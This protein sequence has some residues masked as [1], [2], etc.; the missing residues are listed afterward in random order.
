LG[1]ETKQ[2]GWGFTES[3]GRKNSFKRI[4]NLKGPALN[5]GV[6]QRKCIHLIEETTNK[7]P[8]RFTIGGK[9]NLVTTVTREREGG[10]V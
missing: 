10:R 9:D 1:R 5:V 4:G 2:S 3:V 8:G 6:E 7:T